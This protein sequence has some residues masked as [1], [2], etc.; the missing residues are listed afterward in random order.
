MSDVQFLFA[1]LG[2]LYLWECA[3]WLRRGGVAFSTWAG[4]SWRPH[5]PAALLGNQN[6]GFILSM[7]LPPLGGCFTAYQLPCSLGPDGILFFVSATVNPGWRPT[8]TGRF[9]NWDE[10]SRLR[11][12]GKKIM[13]EKESV[14]SAATA[15]LA[16]HLF[17]SLRSIAKQPGTDRARAI[18]ELL[19]AGFDTKQIETLRGDF[20][21]RVRP[22]RWL[23]NTV[24]VLVF[25]VAPLLISLFR[26]KYVWLTLLIVLLGLTIATAT[27]FARMH[28]RFYPAATDE[29]FSHTLMIA[30]APATT[31][32]AHDMISR[33]LL[34]KFHPLS[35]ARQLLANGAFLDFARR[36]LR[37][38]RHP[39]LP[40]CPNPQPQ[41]IA[42]ESFYRR[43]LLEVTEAWLLENKY[44]PEE[45]CRPPT[46]AE[47]SCRAY[48]PRCEAQFVA[49]VGECTDC[50][51]LPLVAFRKPS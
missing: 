6:G 27:L 34:E 2:A 15:T 48:C 8:Q 28:R 11:L 42:T 32:R 3:S 18:K 12:V 4:Q 44:S 36:A 1:I 23:T 31:M 7:P 49:P 29:R 20:D 30:L 24:F 40:A 5:N 46:P 9:L 51:G 16:H 13:L 14:Y 26:L 35:V 41:A 47:E 22:I 10:A 33:L 37:D 38:L 43:T 50:G 21:R 25:I 17:E 39:A 45:L 19:C